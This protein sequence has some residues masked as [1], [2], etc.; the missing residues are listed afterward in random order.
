MKIVDNVLVK[1]DDSDIKNGTIKIP[2]NVTSIGYYAFFNCTSLKS[3]TIP[4]SVTSI[5]NY[6]FFHCASLK[7]ITIPKSVTSIGGIVFSN[8]YSLKS[9]IIPNSIINIGDYVFF[10]CTSLKSI[11]IPKS[12]TSIGY[13]AFYNCRFLKSITISEN[14]TNIGGEAFYDCMSLKSVVLPA[15]LTSIGEHAFDGHNSLKLLVTP[16][17]R[18]KINV[19][20]VVI[21]SYLYLYANSILKDKYSDFNNFLDNYYIGRVINSDLIYKKDAILKFKNLFYKLRKN[22]NIPHTLFKTLSLEETEKFDYKIWNQIGNLLDVTDI[23][24]AEAVSEMI[25]IFGLFENDNGA[26]GRLQDYI[27]F[28]NNKHIIFTDAIMSDYTKP[29]SYTYCQLKPGVVIPE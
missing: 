15:S 6:A 17:G 1:V 20:N 13:R 23:E 26:R 14:V 5:V 8:C 22:F 2:N 18:I 19:P 11:T 28:I 24:M 12:V 29:V 3:I 4:K 10:N 25:A 27:D 7:S 16:Y 9:I 21:Q